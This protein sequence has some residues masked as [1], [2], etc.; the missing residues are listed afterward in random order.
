MPETRDPMQKITAQNTPPPAEALSGVLQALIAVAAKLGIE[1]HPDQLRRRFAL[2]GAVIPSNTLVAIARELG[3]EARVLHVAFSELPRLSK[4]LPAILRSKDGGALLL[5]DARSDP[6][7][8][9][10]AVIRDPASPP[11]EQLAIEEIRLA[12]VW[13]GEVILIKR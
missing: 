7:K 5:E 3:M 9:A 12:E 10:V 6:M 8:G 4:T 2:S 11:D 1:I 13:E